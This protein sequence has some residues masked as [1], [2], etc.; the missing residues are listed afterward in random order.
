[1]QKHY[2]NQ[3]K[4]QKC[5]SLEYKYLNNKKKRKSKLMNK[6]QKIQKFKMNN[7]N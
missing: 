7:K 2:Y 5:I 3:K 4:T 1:M 6:K